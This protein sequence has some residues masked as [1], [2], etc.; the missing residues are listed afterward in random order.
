MKNKY[1]LTI[2]IKTEVR[3]E[4]RDKL[5]DRIEKM[6]KAM[7][8]TVTKVLEMGKKQLAFKVAGQSEAFY[9]NFMLELLPAEVLQLEKKLTVESQK[10]EILRHLLVK[11]D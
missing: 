3:D 2:M 5:V 7:D 8:G 10:K 11:A 6:V 1:D 9:L 4:A